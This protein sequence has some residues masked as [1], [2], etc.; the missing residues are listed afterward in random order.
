MS[1][2]CVISWSPKPEKEQQP[3]D[4]VENPLFLKIMWFPWF[5]L[6]RTVDSRWTFDGKIN[7]TIPSCFH[8]LM[9]FA[10]ITVTLSVAQ[11]LLDAL[12]RSEAFRL[13]EEAHNWNKPV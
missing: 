7:A 12:L 4:F 1:E 2:V 8:A 11:C 3:C 9:L 6:Q 13:L 10:S 5:I